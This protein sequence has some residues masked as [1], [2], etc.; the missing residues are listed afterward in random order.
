MTAKPTFEDSMNQLETLIRTME[1]GD[2]TL[3]ETLK[4]FEDGNKLVKKCQDDLKNIETKVEKIG[5]Y[6]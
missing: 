5:N 4:L 3:D 1:N 2:T 6:N